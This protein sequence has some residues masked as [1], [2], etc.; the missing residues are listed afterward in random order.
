ME[1]KIKRFAD[2]NLTL[3]DVKDIY[4]ETNAPKGNTGQLIKKTAEVEQASP[5]AKVKLQVASTN[6]NEGNGEVARTASSEIKERNN[7]IVSSLLSKA[8]YN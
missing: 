5:I 7:R 2:L 3:E 6:S 1:K 4:P 8:G